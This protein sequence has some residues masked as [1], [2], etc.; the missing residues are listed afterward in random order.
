MLSAITLSAIMLSAIILS[1][2]IL[3][4]IM[5]S[6]MAPPLLRYSLCKHRFS[7]GKYWELGNWIGW[8]HLVLAEKTN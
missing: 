8:G 1:I 2:M 7:Y 4:V 5:L 6:V 3:S